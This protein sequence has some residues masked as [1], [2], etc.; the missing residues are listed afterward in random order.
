MSDISPDSGSPVYFRVTIDA[1]GLGDTAPKDGFIDPIK[2]ETYREIRTLTSNGASTAING[3]TIKINNVPVTFATGGLNVAGMI[4]A[5]N[6]LSQV[7]KVVASE[8]DGEICLT[9]I[10]DYENE[11]IFVSGDDDVLERTGFKNPVA[12]VT[13]TAYPGGYNKDKALA[14][15]RANMRW[16]GIMETIRLYVVP[17]F[18]TNIEHDG[19]IDA[20]PTSISFTVGF[21]AFQF[22]RMHDTVTPHEYLEGIPALKRMIAR[23]MMNRYTGAKYYVDPTVMSDGSYSYVRGAFIENQVADALTDDLSEAEAAISIAVIQNLR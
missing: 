5:I 22:I 21:D 14:K 2:A 7:H 9:N 20:E 23:G 3:D 11:A 4:V 8:D 18:V 16:V 6:N 19:E 1:T 17:S 15:L 13:P 12:N 10:K